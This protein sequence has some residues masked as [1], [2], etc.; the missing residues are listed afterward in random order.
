VA[1]EYFGTTAEE[2]IAA[3]VPVEE[4]LAAFRD[5]VNRPGTIFSTDHWLLPKLQRLRELLNDPITAD[6]ARRSWMCSINDTGC[7]I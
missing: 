2:R 1:I 3:G 7:E 4:A 6:Q 5:G